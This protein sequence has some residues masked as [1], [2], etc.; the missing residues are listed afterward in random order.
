MDEKKDTDVGCLSGDCGFQVAG[1]NIAC[2]PSG[3]GCFLAVL[4]E[5]EE[6]AFHDAQ[7]VSATQSIKNILA[8]IPAD[9]KGR[10]LSFLK[11]NRGF[12]LA[13]V[14]HS[15]VGYENAVTQNDDDETIAAALRLIN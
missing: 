1:E 14:D 15:G 11:T 6:S 10:K 8:N 2:S 5:A 9:S 3:I 7:L 13:W 4:A 12:L